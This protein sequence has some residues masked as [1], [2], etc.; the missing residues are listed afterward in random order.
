M[1]VE[2]TFWIAVVAAT[3]KLGKGVRQISRCTLPAPPRNSVYRIFS[4]TKTLRLIAADEVEPLTD[5]HQSQTRSSAVVSRINQDRGGAGGPDVQFA[6]PVPSPPIL[7]HNSHCVV[8]VEIERTTLE[9]DGD[10][11]TTC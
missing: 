5:F 6:N 11:M 2:V 10:A 1:I 7:T 9:F 4:S 3:R 8:P